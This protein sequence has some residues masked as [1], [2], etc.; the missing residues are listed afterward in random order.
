VSRYFADGLGVPIKTTIG[1]VGFSVLPL[2]SLLGRYTLNKVQYHKEKS[3]RGQGTY[4][5]L[6]GELM[7][8][9]VAYFKIKATILRKLMSFSIRIRFAFADSLIEPLKPGFSP[10]L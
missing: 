7:S 3:I 8:L 2:D 5:S 9:A 1:P 6:C 4:Q 10:V